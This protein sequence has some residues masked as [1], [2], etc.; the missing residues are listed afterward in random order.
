MIEKA[1]LPPTQFCPAHSRT[2]T[3]V[4]KRFALSLLLVSFTACER[5]HVTGPDQRVDFEPSAAQL[6][7]TGSPTKDEDPS[8]VRA[9][10]GRLF[11]AWFSDRGGNADIYITSTRNGREWSEPV[12]VTMHQG[13]DFHPSLIQDEQG[14]FHLVWFRWTALFRGNIWYNSSSDGLSWDPAREVQVTQAVDVDDWVPTIARAANG[15]LLVYFVS[16]KRWPS[17]TPTSDLYVAV[18]RPENPTFDPVVG[19]SGVNSP[20]EHDHLPFVARTRD[21]FTLVWVRHDTSQPQPWL[22]PPPKS[23]LFYASSLDGLNWIAARRITSETGPVV[24]IFPE[25]YQGQDGEWS[26]LWLSTRD[27]RPAVFE[28]PLANS[29][30]YPQG[31]TENTQLPPGYFHRIVA[32][33]TAG[34]YLGVWVQG[35]VGSEEIYYRFFRK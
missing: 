32:T 28:L 15:T 4:A 16:E 21:Q 13:G 12:R 19:A 34:V 6:L 14:T 11:V 5:R 18:K 17:A 29:D 2:S 35:P 1:D 22:S 9:R 30:V 3:P 7:S 10:D 8:V 26:L 23:D 27:G 31:I 33:S 20:T 24:N 25:L